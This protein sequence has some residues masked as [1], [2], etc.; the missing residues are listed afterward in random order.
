MQGK[1]KK[2]FRL[3]STTINKYNKN[4]NNNMS[5]KCVPHV[6]ALLVILLLEIFVVSILGLLLSESSSRLGRPQELHQFFHVPGPKSH[7][8]FSRKFVIV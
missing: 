1:I 2:R 5:N 6:G 8:I 7:R 4:N 3:S